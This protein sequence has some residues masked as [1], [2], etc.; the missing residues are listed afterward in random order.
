MKKKHYKLEIRVSAQDS[1]WSNGKERLG[2]GCFNLEE[3]G[4]YFGRAKSWC[5]TNEELNLLDIS[6]SDK[7]IDLQDKKLYS[8]IFII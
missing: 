1:T 2:I 6:F 7:R 5:L 8:V 3:D 4:Y